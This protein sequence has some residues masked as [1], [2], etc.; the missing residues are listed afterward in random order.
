[1]KL[2]H[3]FRS[4]ITNLEYYHKFKD[5]ETFENK[6]HDFYLLQSLWILR[7]TDIEESVIWRLSN[8]P[9]DDITFEINKKLFIQ[10]WVKSFDEV[11]KYPKPY[12]SFF[13]GGF[14]EYANTVNKNPKHFKTSLYL[15]AS[16]RFFPQFNDRY[17]IIL[18]E[19]ESDFKKGFNCKP[20]YKTSNPNIFHP[21]D[22]TK[23]DIDIIWTHN[24]S[25]IRYKGAEFFI[26]AISKSKFLK[27][28]N[29]IHTGNNPKTLNNLLNKY[30]VKNVKSVGWIERPELNILLN[31]SKFGLVT[32]NQLDGCP[33]IS[34]EI[35]CSGTP[36]LIRNKTRLLGYYKSKG[37]V[38]FSESDIVNKLNYA[39]DNYSTL[40]TEILESVKKE[41]SMD[42]ICQM[43]FKNW[44]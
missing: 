2:F 14:K 30:G 5:L 36:L 16:K 9:K 32:S 28:L 38:E 26:K 37:V 33:R 25:Q 44:K 24:L 11:F 43:N 15:G 40:K 6:C 1:M 22:N 13:R 7:N 41:L 23:K 42:S 4:N 27:S 31:R 8:K 35:L 39:F 29:I 3:L 12:I 20:F 19:S 21:I 34:T 10:R 17:D 18:L